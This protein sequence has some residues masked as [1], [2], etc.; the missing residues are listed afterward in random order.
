LE[1]RLN[2][3]EF[4]QLQERWRQ[5]HAGVGNAH[6]VGVLEDGAEWVDRKFSQRDMQFEQLRRYSRGVI[7]EA[8]GFPKPLLGDVEDVNRANAEA[9]SFV[10]DKWLMVPRLNKLRT[11]LNDDFLPQYGGIGEG[12]EFDYDPVVEPD[13]GEVRQGKRAR[14]L[15]VASFVREGFDPAS[16]LEQF[17]FDPIPWIGLPADR[18]A[19]LSLTADNSDNGD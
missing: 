3:D 6:R 2:D 5:T 11:T 17:G 4:A 1:G 18:S 19:Q 7:R 9:G 13:P 10:F 16:V 12:L 14:A 15:T 8:W